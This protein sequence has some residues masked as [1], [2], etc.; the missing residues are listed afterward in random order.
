VADLAEAARLKGL[1]LIDDL[2][3]GSLLAT[4]RFGLQHE[5]TVPESVQ[6]G[7]DVTCFSGDKL[8]GGPQAGI[9]VGRRAHIDRLKAHPLARAVRLDKASIAGLLATLR[10]YREGTA[11]RDIPVWRM[12]ATPIDDLNARA[13]AWQRSLVAGGLTAEVVDAVSAVGGGSLPGETLPTRALAMAP[14]ALSADQVAAH[15]RHRQPPLIARI[16]RDRVII[17][18]RTV[19]PADDSIVASHLLQSLAHD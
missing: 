2:G 15:L 19:D 12:I 1:L 8:L 7:A 13:S 6:A 17:D 3:S 14:G 4:E 18:P 5:P 11:V 10:H 16:D 9:I